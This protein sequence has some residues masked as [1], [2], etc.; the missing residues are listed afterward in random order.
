MVRPRGILVPDRKQ[1]EE[2]I[3]S[4]RKPKAPGSDKPTLHLWD[5]KPPRGRKRKKS[6]LDALAQKIYDAFAQAREA[7][8]KLIEEGKDVP[9]YPRSLCAAITE[10]GPQRNPKGCHGA[11]KARTIREKRRMQPKGSS[12]K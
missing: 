3:M 12:S 5:Y 10:R 11:R 8:L 7:D 2:G 6:Y 4:A 9:V 1:I